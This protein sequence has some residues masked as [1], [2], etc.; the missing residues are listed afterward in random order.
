MS[1]PTLPEDVAGITHRRCGASCFYEH[2]QEKYGKCWGKTQAVDEEYD[3][4]EHWW[5]HACEGHYAMYPDFD[6][7]KYTAVRSRTP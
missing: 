1:A 5:T 3:D 7:T 6:L 4:E 2:D